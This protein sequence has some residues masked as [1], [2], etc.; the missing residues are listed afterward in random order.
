MRIGVDGGCWSNA[1]GYG[2]YTREIVGGLVEWIAEHRLGEVRLFVDRQSA[3]TC[4]FPDSARLVEVPTR[5]AASR[6]ARDGGRRSLRDLAAFRAA[7]RPDELDVFFFPSVYTYFPLR[8]GVP[9]VVAVHDAIPEAVPELV[10]PHRRDRLLWSLKVRAALRRADR[11]VTVSRFAREQVLRHHGLDPTRVEVVPEAPAAVFAPPQGGPDPGVLGRYGLTPDL[12]FFLF[13]GGL[14]PHKNLDAALDA[15][16][17][18]E[19]EPG[20]ED[21]C[22][23][24]VGDASRDVFHTNA[25]HLRARAGALR[26]GKVRILGY[27]PDADLVHLYSAARATVLPSFQEGFGLPVFEAAACGGATIATRASAAPELLAGGSL[28]VDPERP[29]ELADAMRRVLA[30]EALRRRLGRLGLERT[31]GLGWRRSALELLRILAR[32]AGSL[33]PPDLRESAAPAP[34][35]EWPDPDRMAAGGGPRVSVIVP[36]HDAAATVEACLSA[37]GSQDVPRASYEVVFVDDASRDATPQLAGRWADRVLRLRG[38]AAGPAA[39]RNAGAAAA[40]GDVLLFLDADVVPAPGTIRGLLQPLEDP[41]L[42]AVFGAYDAE[43]AHASLVSQYRNL[44]HHHVHLTSRG[45]AETFWA[46]CGAVRRAA[47]ES[48]GGFDAAR[49]PVPSIEDIELGRR[50]RARGMR[51]RLDPD[52]Q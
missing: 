24:L 32:S 27:V 4:G 44:L 11:V 17:L 36:G 20:G 10:F 21:A 6:A 41:G 3:E 31:R 42:D 39:A 51:I 48:V 16:E 25:G 9:A 49:Y 12:P 5:E 47:F 2:R 22:L 1:R 14:A 43:P 46:G 26:A 33:L 45:E 19:D 35:P 28:L 38:R 15:L 34:E 29:G 8:G 50:M 13:V 37:L 30:D 40:R 52:V 18:L 23:V 7:V